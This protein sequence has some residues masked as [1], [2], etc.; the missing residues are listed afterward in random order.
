[1]DIAVKKVTML[2]NFYNNFYFLNDGI[3]NKIT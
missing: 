2:D 3:K 1:M